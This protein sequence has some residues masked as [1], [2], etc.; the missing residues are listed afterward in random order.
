[1]LFNLTFICDIK[2]N[3]IICYKNRLCF[4]FAVKKDMS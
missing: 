3:K 4:K 2:Y 1:M